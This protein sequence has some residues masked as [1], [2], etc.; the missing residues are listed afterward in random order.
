M[1]TQPQFEVT[2]YDVEVSGWDREQAFF[3]EKTIL[4]WH[5]NRAKI[6]CVRHPLSAGA[7]VFV[8]LIDPTSYT[9]TFPIAYQTES[10][11][12]PDIRGVRRVVLQQ[13]QPRAAMPGPRRMP[14]QESHEDVT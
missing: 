14:T 7:V 2:H 8:R 11:T 5:E 1:S 9:A 12:P 10:V 3:V 6:I 4:E 13:L